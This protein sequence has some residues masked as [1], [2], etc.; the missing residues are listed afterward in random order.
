VLKR[1]VLP[2]LDREYTLSEV[3]IISSAG[4][5]RALGLPQKGHLGVGADADIAVYNENKDV[6]HM[7]AYP[8]YVI[9]GGEVVVEEGDLRKTVEGREFAVHPTYDEKIEDFLRPLFQQYYTMSFDNYPVE[10]S[11]VHGLKIVDL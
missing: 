9:K 1:I 4:P 8:R 3:A 10:E 7:F 11:R 5:A 6:A 2:E